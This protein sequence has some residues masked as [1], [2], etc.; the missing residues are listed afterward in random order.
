MGIR[1]NKV[2]G[3]GLTNVQTQDDEI[4]DPRFSKKSILNDDED[5]YYSINNYIT[6][7]EQ[8]KNEENK[9]E[10]CLEIKSLEDFKDSDLDRCFVHGTEYMNPKVFCC[11]PAC[12]YSQWS[13]HDDMIDYIEANRTAKNKVKKINSPLYP[14]LSYWDNRDGRE[15]KQYAFEFLRNVNYFKKNKR[16]YDGNE[17]AQLMGFED[18][19][20]CIRHMR[21]MV[22]ETVQLQLEYANIFTDPKIVYQL[23]PILYTYWT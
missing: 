6:W 23:E 16:P 21:P 9:F 3:Y 15:I 19:E 8:K 10:I 2:L 14:W 1:I 22:P 5:S 20:T 12:C 7:L 13:R 4:I 17:L 18:M 11:I